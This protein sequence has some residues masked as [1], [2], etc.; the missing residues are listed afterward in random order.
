MP[1]KPTPWR[2]RRMGL[3]VVERHH[4]CR[5]RRR[6]WVWPS[7]PTG[8][9]LPSSSPSSSA[10]SSSSP[11]LS[12][13]PVP[14]VRN[15]SPSGTAPSPKQVGKMYSDTI[16]Q[17]RPVKKWF[18]PCVVFHYGLDEKVSISMKI[19]FSTGPGLNCLGKQPYMYCLFLYPK[20][21]TYF[22][23]FLSQPP[24]ISWPLRM[25]AKTKWWTCCL[26]WRRRRAVRT[27]VVWL[28][29]LVIQILQQML[30]ALSC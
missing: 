19:S 6:V 15:T 23:S 1:Q 7:C 5:P 8:G 29:V 22:L 18:K 10:S 25:Q 11:S 30:H 9:R 12:S 24:M 20:G 28:K 2:G 26:S 16:D 14:S 17:R 13:S 21:S 4:Q 27:L 3:R